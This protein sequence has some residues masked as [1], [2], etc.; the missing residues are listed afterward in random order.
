MHA[1][2]SCIAVACGKVHEKN[3]ETNK[4]T[5]N[6][7]SDTVAASGRSKTSKGT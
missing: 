7:F 2:K 6:V 4:T 1:I 3:N 5:D